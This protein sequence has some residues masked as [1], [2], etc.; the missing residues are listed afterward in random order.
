MVGRIALI[1]MT[2]SLA[3]TACGITGNLRLDPG[4]AA[5]KSPGILNSDREF[6]LSLGPLPLW[7]L[8]KG[9]EDDPD[10]IFQDL[11]AIRFY[12]YEIE[13]GSEKVRT[14]MEATA[15]DLIEKGWAPMAAVR[16]DGGLVSV[17][18][19][20][21]RDQ[22]RGLAIIIHE[23]SELVLLNLIGRIQPRGLLS[24]SL[25]EFDIP[26]MSIREQSARSND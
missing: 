2:G 25:S 17:L 23:D 13:G 19:K 4:Y 26:P 24:S 16:E 5:F 3:L 11:D 7:L 18:A 14:R 12:C 6:A 8:R 20:Q 9:A 15:A 22:I 1:V 21:D 10:D